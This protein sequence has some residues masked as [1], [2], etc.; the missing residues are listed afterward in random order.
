MDYTSQEIMFQVSD[1]W[2]FWGW[3]NVDPFSLQV[4]DLK[5]KMPITMKLSR[6]RMNLHNNDDEADNME[7][8]FFKMTGRLEKKLAVTIFCGVKSVPI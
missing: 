3:K 4:N 7:S 1:S 8:S 2:D 5:M 6:T